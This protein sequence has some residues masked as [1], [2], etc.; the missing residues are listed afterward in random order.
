M[1]A[2]LVPVPVPP[3]RNGSQKTSFLTSVQ[4]C[5]ALGARSPPRPLR[6][7]KRWRRKT[8]TAGAGMPASPRLPFP[9]CAL[10]RQRRSQRLQGLCRAQPQ[11]WCFLARR[12]KA[13]KNSDPVFFHPPHNV[14]SLGRCG[15]PGADL[16][17]AVQKKHMAI[18]EC[19]RHC[20]AP[21]NLESCWVNPGSHYLKFMAFS[22]L[23]S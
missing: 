15:F 11:P 17:A 6:E 13:N 4:L 2:A 20:S 23:S 22:F 18:A 3:E 7:N 16:K 10:P 5:P 1:D 14:C 9:P 8:G 19:R 12:K 21:A